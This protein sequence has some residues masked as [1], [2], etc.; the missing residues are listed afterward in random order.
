MQGYAGAQ[1]PWESSAEL[2]QEVTPPIGVLLGMEQHVSM[3]VAHAFAQFA[4]ATGDSE[5][6]RNSAWPVCREVARWLASRVNKTDPGIRD[7]EHGG[8][9]G[10]PWRHS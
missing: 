6:A 9:R 10:E 7:H 5:F 3:S 4:H 1:F 2:G 8:H